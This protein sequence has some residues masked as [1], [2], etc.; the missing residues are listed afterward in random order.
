MSKQAKLKTQR[1][2][3]GDFLFVF[4]EADDSAYVH[5]IQNQIPCGLILY[6]DAI[7]PNQIC[8]AHYERIWEER[9]NPVHLE[10]FIQKFSKE[11]DY[12]DSYRVNGMKI[13]EDF[14]IGK[15]DMIDPRTYKAIQRINFAPP[16]TLAFRDFANLKTYGKDS[17]SKMRMEELQGEVTQAELAE[18][19]GQV[20]PEM[21]LLVLRWIKRGL[22]LDHAIHKVK[23]D[24][25]ISQNAKTYHA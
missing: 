12:R 24:L 16:H 11:G 1:R 21:V 22:R 3:V 14:Q 2:K 25:E 15:Q 20:P 9:P 4:Y 10:N 18:I 5:A 19:K 7:N 23:C 8:V 17:I 6:I 13:I